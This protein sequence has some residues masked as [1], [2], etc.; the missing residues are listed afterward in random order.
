MRTT[1][2]TLF[3][4]CCV[5]LI[6]GCA[7]TLPF[8]QRMSYKEVSAAKQLNAR[9][10]GPISLQWDPSTFPDRVDVQGASGFVGGGSQTRVPTG[11]ALASRITEA[12]DASIGLDPSSSRRLTIKVIQAKSTF[13]YSAGF[14]N[15]TPALDV[16]ACHL[17][18]EFTIGDKSWRDTFDSSQRDPTVGG[19]SATAI[20]EAAWDDVAL[21]VARSVV[22][23]LK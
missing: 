19:S 3:V 20:L 8:N 23:H 4:L 11:V 7:I 21:Q 15:V 6:G 14:F 18:T 13:Q 1:A 17:E 16:G 10:K 2:S 22:S 9:D 5:A 12:L